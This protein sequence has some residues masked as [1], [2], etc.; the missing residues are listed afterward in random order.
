MFN[1]GGTPGNLSAL[2]ANQTLGSFVFNGYDGSSN[3]ISAVIQAQTITNS[4]DA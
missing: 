1:Y 3:V 2:G 4:R